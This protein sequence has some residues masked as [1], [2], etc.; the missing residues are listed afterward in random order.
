MGND[1]QESFLVRIKPSDVRLVSLDDMQIGSIHCFGMLFLMT[2]RAA[3][4]IADLNLGSC[5]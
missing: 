5:L 2:C 1:F 4:T 3:N